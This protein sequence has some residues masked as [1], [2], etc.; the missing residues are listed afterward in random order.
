MHNTAIVV[1]FLVVDE[2]QLYMT[3]VM[4]ASVYVAQL[5]CT[6]TAW[7][8]NYIAYICLLLQ[9]L[10]CWFVKQFC[11]LVYPLGVI[12]TCASTNNTNTITLSVKKN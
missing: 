11:T 1:I 10:L 6:C 12:Y 3:A 5:S 4:H 7:N 8:I 2:P 9:L